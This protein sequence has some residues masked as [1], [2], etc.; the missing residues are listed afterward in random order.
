LKLKTLTETNN[1]RKEAGCGM[2]CFK[3]RKSKAEAGG[4]SDGEDAA[5]ATGGNND[6]E[7]I[8]LIASEVDTF[9]EMDSNLANE[10]KSFVKEIEDEANSDAEIMAHVESLLKTFSS[11]AS[12]SHSSGSMQ[13]KKKLK[14]AHSGYDDFS[15]LHY[16]A[17]AARPKLCEF[18][19]SELGIDVNIESKSKLTP[20]HV[21]VKSH[22]FPKN[23]LVLHSAGDKKAK[24][25]FVSEF[26][27][28]S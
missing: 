22:S 2:S 24:V 21:L 1:A 14:E 15:L 8:P 6:E 27:F 9:N 3:G 13:L 23:Q 5:D 18:L 16:A 28:L 12:L 20:L 10:M 4:G 26:S 19:I 11:A 25:A 7:A 17:K